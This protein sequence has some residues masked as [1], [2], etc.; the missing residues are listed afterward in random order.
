MLH[1]F[2]NGIFQDNW[3]L[4]LFDWF[5]KF[6]LSN[7]RLVLYI[8]FMPQILLRFSA[9]IRTIVVVAARREKVIFVGRVNINAGKPG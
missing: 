8:D 5:A 3:V 4:S 6:N 1:L 7:I 2:T 9:D